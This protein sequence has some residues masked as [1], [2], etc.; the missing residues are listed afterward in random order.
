VVVANIGDVRVERTAEGARGAQVLVE[1]P[2]PDGVSMQ[3]NRGDGTTPPPLSTR[4]RG[5][6]VMPPGVFWTGL[7]LTAAVG[8]LTIWSGV[9]TLSGVDA[10]E[11]NP[12]EERYDAGQR[13][14][15]RTNALIGATAGL[16]FVTVLTAFFTDFEGDPEDEDRASVTIAPST[17]GAMLYVRG[18]L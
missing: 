9:D 15:R 3:P 13:K 17:D 4:D 8:G 18:A 12:S 1:I 10:Y 6:R 5:V 16:A 7:G 2:T 11:E 14:E